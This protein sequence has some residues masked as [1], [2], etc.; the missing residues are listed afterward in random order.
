MK[1]GRNLAALARSYLTTLRKYQARETEAVLEEAY[2]LGRAAMAA[3]LGV[4][5]M[6]R[7]H[8]Q[9]REKVLRS[10]AGG[11]N[12][13]RISK[14]AGVLFL[15]ALSPFEATHRGFRETNAELM[16]RNRELA[17]EIRERQR[18]E[19]AL[20]ASERR[21]GRLIETAQDVIFSLAPDGRIVALNRAFETITGWPRAEWLGRPF[22]LL[23][24]P[25]EAD[26]ALERFHMVLEGRPP[27]VWEYRVRAASGRY[28]VGEFTLTREVQ[29]GRIVGVFGI[30]RD[31][32][33]RK[34]A[35]EALQ[36][37][38]RR[39]L[40]AQE[41]ERRRISRELHDEVGQ[42]LTAISV[43]LANLRNNG[44]A[45]VAG[46][47]QKVTLS[48]RLLQGTMENV[49]RF[50]RELRP[51]MLDELGLLPALRS[52]M[53]NFSART[54]LRVNFT[55][56]PQA[57]QLDGERKTALFRIAQESLTNVAKHARAR[58]VNVSVCGT[59]AG[60]CMEIADNGRSFR[61]NSRTAAK[62]K[63]RLGLLGMQER[64]RLLN[65]QFSIKPVPGRGTTVRVTIPFQA[66]AGT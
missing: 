10:D 60:I 58:R 26:V 3:G 56:D 44:T 20:R 5:D 64:V 2:E 15:Q 49:H 31:I 40:H 35:E 66:A 62:Q 24:H 8:L 45:T 63:Q 23:I 46:L 17:A 28:L 57:E 43:A 54:G 36:G 53:K 6:A 39:I 1:H 42:S 4:L 14:L 34:R 7:V 19:K 18:T 47:A 41:E 25:A 21:Y 38:S 52:H 29:D 51:A 32:T 16:K 30:G 59:D 13:V 55:A 65:G 12:R 48:Q 50:A 11:K 9:A 22:S 27:A 33:A 61:L 37:F